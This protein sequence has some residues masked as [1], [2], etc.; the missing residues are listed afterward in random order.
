MAHQTPGFSPGQGR[1]G[2]TTPPGKPRAIFNARKILDEIVY[3]TTAL[4]GN[5]LTFPEVKTLIDG[6][7]VCGRRTIDSEQVLNQHPPPRGADG[8]R[9]Q[10]FREAR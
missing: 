6:I 3:N 7:T 9:D 2:T 5:P 8:F 10:S 4:E 1:I